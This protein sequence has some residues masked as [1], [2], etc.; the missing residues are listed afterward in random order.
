[1]HGIITILA[2]TLCISQTLGSSESVRNA[3]EE[4]LA[5]IQR[6]N[7]LTVE[8]VPPEW[9]A[10]KT[11]ETIKSSTVVQYFRD[12]MKILQITWKDDWVGDK[13]GFF[14]GTVFANGVT[15]ARLMSLGD[16][17][18]VSVTPGI[19]DYTVGV[20]IKENSKIEINISFQD[21][22]FFDGVVVDGRN[23]RLI[24]DLEFTKNVLNFEY[25]IKPITQ[26]FLD[27]IRSVIE[28][29]RMNR[30]SK[31]TKTETVEN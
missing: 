1:M 8:D 29:M 24:D 19:I 5:M 6:V 22:E 31:Q 18:F 13:G 2:L 21:G 25:A 16:S 27:G 20:L 11:I 14:G 10:Q 9:R 30:N 26:S 15:V 12:E 7:S 4:G 17:V 23:S 3:A 28:A